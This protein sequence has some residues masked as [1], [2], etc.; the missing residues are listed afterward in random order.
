MRSVTMGTRVDG[1]LFGRMPVAIRIASSQ[2]R[3]A[4]RRVPA[5]T[6]RAIVMMKT[7]AVRSPYPGSECCPVGTIHQEHRQNGRQANPQQNRGGIPGSHPSWVFCS[8]WTFAEM[9]APIM[10]P[11]TPMTGRIAFFEIGARARLVSCHDIGH[12][13]H[14]IP[15]MA[16]HTDP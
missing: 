16:G 14:K 6:P 5:T 2:P 12:P 8:M 4:C 11:A 3:L 10:N 9:K 15:H 13:I 7:R 1:H